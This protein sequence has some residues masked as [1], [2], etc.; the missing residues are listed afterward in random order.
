MDAKVLDTH[1]GMTITT[2]TNYR[3]PSAGIYEVEFGI[4]MVSASGVFITASIQLDGTQLT[5][6][7]SYTGTPLPGATR[8]STTDSDGRSAIAKI[9]R[10][11][12][13]GQVVRPIIFRYANSLVEIIGG[14]TWFS[15]K[16]VG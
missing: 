12:N 10:S 4:S 6:A 3:F 2:D 7:A 11:F 15:V 9:T 14:F 8:F 13:G 5:D 16:K 1:N